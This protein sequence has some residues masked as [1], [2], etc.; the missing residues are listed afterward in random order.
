[1]PTS[2]IVGTIA[3]TDGTGVTGKLY[4]KL[5]APLIDTT[6][7]PDTVRYSKPEVYT[8]TSGN[9]NT[10]A[11]NLLRSDETT[12]NFSFTY[13]VTETVY[14]L[15]GAVYTGDRHNDSGT[16]FTG[17]AHPTSG[18]QALTVQNRVTEVSLF[19]PF[20]AHILESSGATVE[21]AS[22]QPSNVNFSNIDTSLYYIAQL[23]TQTS[24]LLQSLVTGI[25]NPRGNY[26]A[27][28]S[29]NKGDVVYDPGTKGSYWYIFP[30]ASTGTPL[31]DT[32]H[33]QILITS[34]EVTGGSVDFSPV[35]MNDA[36]GASWNGIT[37]KA[38]N[39][40]VL[41]DKIQTLA[42]LADATFTILKAPTKSLGT[43]T[44]D[45]ASTAFVQAA[46]GAYTPPAPTTAPDIAISDI[47]SKIINSRILKQILTRF[48]VAE[49]RQ[50]QGS[51]GGVITGGF[52][53]RNLN[54]MVTNLNSTSVGLTGGYMQLTAGKY[55]VEG[56]SVV[57]G[58]DRNRA[59]LVDS[60]GVF[61][62]LGLS[63]ETGNRGYQ[64]SYRGNNIA[65]VIGY[66]EITAT[67]NI[68]IRHY[69]ETTGNTADSGKPSNFGGAEVFAQ[70]CV[71]KISD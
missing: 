53:N 42:S 22:L 2:Q 46:L 34:T 65:E 26:S 6:T 63:Q 39:A 36:Y 11:I 40:D 68:T 60:S 29:Y 5:N 54:T 49:E 47:S 48:A 28:T 19:D 37:N 27:G 16:W 71:W 12:Y 24:A 31:T 3:D 32:A 1:M 9:L 41:Y 7:T 18:E 13:E 64:L 56:K 20:D 23:I 8:I 61:L 58:V 14:Y 67:T 35:F 15:N 17:A 62:S 59:I 38:P 52:K 10:A 45:V 4:V 44:T 21:W 51:S 66:L 57:S 43:S 25:Y 70:L 69:V 30:T 33:W 55:W 50:P